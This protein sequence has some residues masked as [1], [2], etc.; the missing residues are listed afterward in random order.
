[1]AN[2]YGQVRLPRFV[3]TI[4]DHPF[5]FTKA[6]WMLPAENK[7][8][9]WPRSGEIDIMESRGNDVIMAGETNIGNQEVAS[10]L[11]FGANHQYAGVSYYNRPGFHK[12]FHVYK[13]EWTPS[14]K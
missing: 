9:G 5:H 14:T 10:T 12:D 8:G 11:H 3:L 7:Y 1:M 6:I 2:F 4:N 13:A